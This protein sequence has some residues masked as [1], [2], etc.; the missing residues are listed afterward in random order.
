M[1]LTNYVGNIPRPIATITIRITATIIVT[2][3]PIFT[4]EDSSSKNR[5]R[6]APANGIGPSLPRLLDRFDLF[7]DTYIPLANKSKINSK[8]KIKNESYHF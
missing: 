2:T 3:G 5:I 8:L 6:P 7:F 4:P 1:F